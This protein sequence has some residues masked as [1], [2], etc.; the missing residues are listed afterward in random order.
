VGDQSARFRAAREAVLQAR[1]EAAR[2]WWQRRL[3]SLPSRAWHSFRQWVRDADAQED[4]AGAFIEF[5]ALAFVLAVG[6]LVAWAWQ[7]APVP[8]AVLVAG[9]L[10]FLG[11]GG[12]EFFRE[13]RRGR[14]T[15]IAVGAFG[16]VALWVV[17][18]LVGALPYFLLY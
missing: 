18:P 9:A 11:Y 14:L 13:R 3:F 5:A 16:F 6:L 1:L 10:A 15:V 12:V 4:V 8:T 17:L 7:E 2:P